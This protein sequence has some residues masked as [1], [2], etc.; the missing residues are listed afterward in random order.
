V[1]R[2]E[3][4]AAPGIQKASMQVPRI[5]FVPL[6]KENYELV[7][8]KEDLEKPEFQMVLKVI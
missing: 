2:R 8:R 6:Q 3:A 7:I 1:A 5:D 4:D